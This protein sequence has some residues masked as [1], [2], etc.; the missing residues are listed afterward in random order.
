MHRRTRHLHVQ[1]RPRHD[2]TSDSGVGAQ[3][4]ADLHASACLSIPHP[5]GV[6]I[7][8]G[9]DYIS[10]GMPTDPVD[11]IFRSIECPQ[12]RTVGGGPHFHGAYL[13]GHMS[14]RQNCHVDVTLHSSRGQQRAIV[15]KLDC[16]NRI[17]MTVQSAHRHFFRGR[18]GTARL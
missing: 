16:N 10:S 7:R 13:S 18:I 12:Q 1:K 14:V 17:R 15:I 9:N 8:T 5:N 11:G 6:I 4:E 2:G 3:D